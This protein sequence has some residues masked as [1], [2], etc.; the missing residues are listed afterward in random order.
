MAGRAGV[1][2][3]ICSE[4]FARRIGGHAARF[5]ATHTRTGAVDS[6]FRHGMSLRLDGE[7]SPVLISVQTTAA[8]FH[9][10]AIEIDAL[11]EL[12]AGEPTTAHPRSIRFGNRASIDLSGA[13]LVSLE[14]PPYSAGEARAA[15]GRIPILA[16]VAAEA[17]MVADDP[18]WPSIREILSAWTESRDPAALVGLIGLGAGSTPAGDD[19]LVGLLAGLHAR[20]CRD[21]VDDEPEDLTPFIRPEL[22]RTTLGSA[23]MIA[24]ALESS[25]P[26]PLLRVIREMGDP[27]ATD[28]PLRTDLHV[29][30]KLGASS[31]YA[32]LTGL[33]SSLGRW[34]RADSFR[35]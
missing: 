14:I 7:E 16:E 2:I 34:L 35:P 4:M 23:Q 27:A 12:G 33:R 13:P 18:F 8:A 11:P 5:L 25:L 29:V 10:W 19:V 9:P 30:L 32:M 22:V 24:S 28:G 3:L 20:A 15:Q 26:E 1:L 17:A 6:T 31:G 21:V